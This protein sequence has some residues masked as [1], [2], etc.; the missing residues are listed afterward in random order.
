MWHWTKCFIIFFPARGASSL[1]YFHIFFPITFL[2]EAFIRNVIIILCINYI[3]IICSNNNNNAV[4]NID[5]EDS[6]TLL[7]II[8]AMGTRKDLFDIYR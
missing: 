7:C 6:K 4:I 3:I 2:E 5:M 8:I 1:S